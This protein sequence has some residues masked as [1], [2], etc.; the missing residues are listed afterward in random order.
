MDISDVITKTPGS[1]NFDII[2][3]HGSIVTPTSVTPTS[4]TPTSVTPIPNSISW[5]SLLRYGLIVFIVAYIGYSIYNAFYPTNVGTILSSIGFGVGETV[6]QTTYNTAEGAKLGVDIVAGTIDNATTLLEKSVGVKGVQ[7]NRIDDKK[8]T[9]QTAIN[10]AIKKQESYD[11]EPDNAGSITQQS[12]SLPK[13]GYCYIG[14]DRG[15]R[16]CVKVNH[17]DTCMSGDIF[18]SKDICVNP[19]LRE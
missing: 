12:R 10:S 15:I 9:T 19:S 11:P 18:P 4:V 3:S 1:S 8:T 6:K 16:S 17:S 2:Y 14:E 5:T 7:F 13:S